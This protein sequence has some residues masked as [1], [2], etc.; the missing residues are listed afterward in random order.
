MPE[1]QPV[2]SPLTRAAVFLVLTLE[3]GGEETVREV[4]ADAPGMARAIG[5]R[6][7]EAS[8]SC[9]AGI[10]SAAYDAVYGT[11]SGG[12]RPAG[13]HPFAEIRGPVHTAPA[14]GGDVF[15]HIKAEQLDLCFELAARLTQRLRG[16]ARVVDEVHGFRYFDRRDLL[17]FVD[18]TE[19]PVGQAVDAALLIGDEDPGFAGG[20][21][22]IIQQYLHDLDAWNA[23]AVE[24]QEAAVGREKLSD[25]ELPDDQKAPGAHTALT[26]IEDEDGNELAILRDN[27]PFG[28]VADGEYGTYFIGYTKDPGVIERML[29]NM[30]IGDPPGTTDRLLEVSRA[31]TGALFYVPSV[32]QLEAAVP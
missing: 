13:L 30:F 7:V 8:L 27:M 4:L 16:A 28:R 25:I 19:N 23:M 31:T 3:A 18:G 10:G 5:F 1:P 26:S 21:Y 22:V 2:T 12:S 14:T 29:R 15:F 17:G 6:N 24:H 20:S 9:V 11:V 32:D